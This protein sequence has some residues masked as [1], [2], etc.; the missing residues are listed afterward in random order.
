[1]HVYV[2]VLWELHII[3]ILI[4]IIVPSF[5]FTQTSYSVREDMGP[6]VAG[7]LLVDRQLTFDIVVNVVDVVGGTATGKTMYA[8]TYSYVLY[9]RNSI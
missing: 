3:D 9:Y 5:R 8:W 2:L 4:T 1:M 7:I 6:A